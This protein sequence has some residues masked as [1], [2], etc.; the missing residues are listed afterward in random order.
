MSLYNLNF[1]SLRLYEQHL[2]CVS[3]VSPNFQPVRPLRWRWS[4]C[5]Q[6]YHGWQTA[7]RPQFSSMHSLA[8]TTDS[9]QVPSKTLGK[10]S[11]D[12][13]T[14]ALHL[15]RPLGKSTRGSNLDWRYTQ[16]QAD[17]LLDT[18]FLRLQQATPVRSSRHSTLRSV[19]GD[20]YPVSPLC[21]L[22]QLSAHSTPFLSVPWLD[23]GHGYT[24]PSYSYLV[25]SSLVAPTRSWHPVAAATF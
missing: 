13:T 11:A 22:R 25:P 8:S 12:V 14:G 21:Q 4:H 23:R 18:T 7:I 5:Q 19:C 15:R 3:V 9:G 24:I 2:N 17:A 1:T 20:Q 10:I 16:T 6:G